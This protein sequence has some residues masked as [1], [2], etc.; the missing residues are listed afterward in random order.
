MRAAGRFCRTSLRAG[1]PM[2]RS[3]AR[4]S[5]RPPR[6]Q[7]GLPRTPQSP[8]WLS[9]RLRHPFIIENRPGAGGNVGTEAV[10]RASADGYTLLLVNTGNSIN[11][12]LYDNRLNFNFIRDIAPVASIVRSPFVMVVNPSFSATTVPEFIAYAQAN[13]GKTTSRQ[14]ASA[15]R[16]IWRVS[17]SR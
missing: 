10:V 6:T 4:R 16:S 1:R 9:E 7:T 11:P 13:P 12:S 8:P 15:H 5:R 17:C 14:Q 3:L 2:R